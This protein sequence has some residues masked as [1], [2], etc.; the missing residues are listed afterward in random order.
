MIEL[1]LKY[2]IGG[3]TGTR[4]GVWFAFLVTFGLLGLAIWMESNDHDMSNLY[5]LLTVLCPIT[6]GAVL[7]AHGQHKHL[8]AKGSQE[9]LE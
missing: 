1:F 3:K 2:I 4:E 9:R 7:G 5:S 8:Q 6:V